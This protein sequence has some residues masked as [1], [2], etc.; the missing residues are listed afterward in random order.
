METNRPSPFPFMET[1]TKTNLLKQEHTAL[2]AE[3]TDAV[4][5]NLPREK[6]LAA[7][8]M[9]QTAEEMKNPN[10]I[11]TSGDGRGQAAASIPRIL[12][13]RWELEY[14]GCWRDKSFVDEFLYD[15]PQCQ[16]PGYKPRPKRMY[17]NMKHGNIKLNNKGGDLYLDKKNAVAASIASGWTPPI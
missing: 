2:A 7:K 4:R 5:E 1:I 12:F 16:I 11:P 14:A 10:L 8:Q 9:E 15:N 17:F 6:M 13:L 3:I